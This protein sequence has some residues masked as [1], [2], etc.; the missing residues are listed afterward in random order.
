MT[1]TSPGGT[2]AAPAAGI[3][4]MA[5]YGH[6]SQFGYDLE[7]TARDFGASITAMAEALA[8]VQQARAPLPGRPAGAGPPGACGHQF[9][10]PQTGAD[11][12][13]LLTGLGHAREAGDPHALPLL[14]AQLTGACEPRSRREAGYVIGICQQERAARRAGKG[15]R[16][17]TGW[18][19][20]PGRIRAASI[21]PCD[22]DGLAAALMAARRLSGTDG[23]GKGR[24]PRLHVVA[25]QAGS[26]S[27][28][29]AAYAAGMPAI[30]QDAGTAAGAGYEGPGLAALARAIGLDPGAGDPGTGLRS[31]G[32]RLPA[33][34]PARRAPGE[35]RAAMSRPGT[36]ARHASGDPREARPREPGRCSPSR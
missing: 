12:L 29:V 1:T 3:D 33:G 25:R 36:R 23:P 35:G 10:H 5:A 30:T 32:F 14:V 13:R 15:T 27:L 34:P 26:E 22:D 7:A 9:H 31:L 28:V 20:G 17:V 18:V 19:T 21:Q 4:L 6:W 2:P 16:Y 11:R 8:S 24:G